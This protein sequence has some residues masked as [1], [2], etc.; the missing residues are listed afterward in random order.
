MAASTAR[1]FVGPES[2]ETHASTL[3]LTC[4]H[5]QVSLGYLGVAYVRSAQARKNQLLLTGGGPEGGAP[6]LP[7]ADFMKSA[8]KFMGTVGLPYLLQRTVFESINSQLSIVFQQRVVYHLRVD[9]ML[10]DGAALGATA[11]SN[12][13]V[14]AHAEALTDVV[15]TMYNLIERKLFSLPKMAL[16]VLSHSI[17]LCCRPPRHHL[18]RRVQIVSIHDVNGAF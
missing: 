2:W 16:P 8:L 4:I 10:S 14:D 12:L 7:A 5:C 17:L 9:V 15:T 1:R 13:T 6:K 3:A 11:G 18:A